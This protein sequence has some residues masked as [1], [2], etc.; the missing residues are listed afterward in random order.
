MKLS[1]FAGMTPEA[2]AEKYWATGEPVTDAR[3]EFFSWRVG[4]PAGSVELAISEEMLVSHGRAYL[5]PKGN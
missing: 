5:V 4:A 1:E 3:F 2:A